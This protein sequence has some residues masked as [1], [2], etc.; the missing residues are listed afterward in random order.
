MSSG[1]KNNN[2]LFCIGTMAKREKSVCQFVSVNLCSD[3]SSV[4][5]HMK[6]AVLRM[7]ITEI[8]YVYDLD[9][10]ESLLQQTQKRV[11]SK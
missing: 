7:H 8:A 9:R 4:H 3:P 5:N 2:R 10:I 1:T 6:R 11:S